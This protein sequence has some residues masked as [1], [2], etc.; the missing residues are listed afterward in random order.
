[1]IDMQA[2]YNEITKVSPELKA[3]TDLEILDLYET[4]PA[5]EIMWELMLERERRNI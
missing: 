5:G 1:M 3:M 4:N 2:L